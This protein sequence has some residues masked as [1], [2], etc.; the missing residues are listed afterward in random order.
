M[1]EKRMLKIC[2]WNA[3][4]LL[5]KLDELEIFMR[6]KDTDICLKCLKPT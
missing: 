2:T 1:N 5:Q 4:G 3:N 6:E